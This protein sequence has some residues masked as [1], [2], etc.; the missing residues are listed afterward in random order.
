MKLRSPWVLG[1]LLSLALAGTSLLDQASRAPGGAP[2]NPGGVIRL[3]VIANSDSSTD[4]AVKLKVRDAV[5]DHLAP[6]L[7]EAASAAETRRVV[8]RVLPGLRRAAEA[9][10]RRLG[11]DDAVQVEFADAFFPLRAYGSLTLPAGEYDALR[12]VIGAGQGHNWWSVLFPP[13]YL[14]DPAWPVAVVAA[15]GRQVRVV[16]ASGEELFLQAD[17]LPD[18]PPRVRFALLEWLRNRGR[19]ASLQHYLDAGGL[20]Y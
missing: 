7:R 10:L 1:A 5:I 19:W 9:Q 15:P 8:R 11:R 12:V 18:G 6:A 20:I 16:T 3:H 4:Q 14:V 17:E 2:G 13:L